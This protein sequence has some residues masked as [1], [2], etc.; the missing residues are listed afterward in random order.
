MGPIAMKR[1]VKLEETMV[2]KV[3]YY[4]RSHA[5]EKPN[6]QSK[7]LDEYNSG[8]F[9]EAFDYA[10][11]GTTRWIKIRGNGRNELNKRRAEEA[12]MLV[13]D[14]FSGLDLLI[15]ATEKETRRARTLW[16]QKPKHEFDSPNKPVVPAENGQGPQIA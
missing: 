15:R 8:D 2:F 4:G 11:T 6:T 13:L 14:P 16:G 5:R 9:V 7:I 1:M 10:E 12:W 3:V